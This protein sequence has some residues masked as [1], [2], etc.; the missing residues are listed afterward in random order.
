MTIMTLREFVFY[1]W[2]ELC[3]LDFSLWLLVWRTPRTSD[4]WKLRLRSSL[5]VLLLSVI[6]VSVDSLPVGLWDLQVPGGLLPAF[7]LLTILETYVGMVFW[8]A[9]VRP[10]G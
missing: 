2:I 9:L 10:N 7:L 6:V 8:V 4:R 3:S 5:V 1:V